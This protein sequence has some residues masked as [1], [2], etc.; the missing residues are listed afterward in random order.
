MIQP[1]TLSLLGGALILATT[2]ALATDNSGLY[3]GFKI[4]ASRQSIGDGER[5]SPRQN[6]LLSGSSAQD[7]MMRGKLREHILFVSLRKEF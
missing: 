2:A 4:S 3:A 7:E 5:V 1:N 6:S